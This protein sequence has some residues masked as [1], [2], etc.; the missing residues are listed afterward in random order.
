MLK[1]GDQVP[2]FETTDQ[3]GNP[4]TLADIKGKKVILFFYPRDNTPTCTEEVC[5]LRDNYDQLVEM[6]YTLIGVSA[7]EVKKHQKFIAKYQLPFPLLA[8]TERN[9]IDKFGVWGPKQF[10]GREIIGIHR[11]TFIIN[12]EG[13]ISHIFEKVKSKQHTAQIVEALEN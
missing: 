8:D 2:E 1:V 5:N 11:T 7:D 12:S 10:M 4:F 9:L 3:N 6:G 13:V